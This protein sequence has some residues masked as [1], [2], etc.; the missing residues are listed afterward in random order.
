MEK[1]QRAKGAAKVAMACR[2]KPALRDSVKEA[3][4]ANGVSVSAFVEQAL[5]EKLAA[6]QPGPS[7]AEASAALASE[8][9]A[10]RHRIESLDKFLDAQAPSAE[11][12]RRYADEVRASA[13]SVRASTDRIMNDLAGSM[14]G[15][16][17]G[18]ECLG[19]F[20]GELEAVKKL[21]V[22]LASCDKNLS[23]AIAGLA[24]TPKAIVSKN[25]RAMLI[26]ATT[27]V[28]CAFIAAFFLF[29]SPTKIADFCRAGAKTA[30]AASA[31]HVEVARR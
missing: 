17:R 24:E 2:W 11:E 18:Q 27:V 19:E 7:K 9:H 16:K 4:A 1:A 14:D 13:E 15:F 12:A 6:A 5:E 20:S 21:L 28:S 30:L 25:R 31:K 10:I 29:P 22:N 8:V 3:A 23:N 26:A